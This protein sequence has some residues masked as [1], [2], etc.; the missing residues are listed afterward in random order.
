MNKMFS[1]AI[2][3]LIICLLLGS[4]LGNVQGSNTMLVQEGDSIE[5]IKA[6]LPL[7]SATSISAGNDHTCAITTEGGVKCWGH[8]GSGQ[9]GDGTTDDSPT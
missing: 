6:D 3:G 4:S 5:G 9:L 2:S 1:H 8:N 7:T